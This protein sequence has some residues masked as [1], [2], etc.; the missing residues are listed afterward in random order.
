A[1]NAKR[2]IS[3]KVDNKSIHEVLNT[4][5][6]GAVTAKEKGN[7]IILTK[8]R[9]TTSS[10]QKQETFILNGYVI[11]ATDSSKIASASVYERN[12]MLSTITDRYGFFSLRIDKP[13]EQTSVYISKSDYID[14]VLIFN[15][16]GQHFSNIAL[17]KRI[18]EKTEEIVVSEIASEIYT[19]AI[20]ADSIF[21]ADVVEEEL[22][23]T[24]FNFKLPRFNK[25]L[26]INEENISDTL[27]RNFQ[28]SLVP[29]VGTNRKLSGNA[30]N[31]Y[32]LNI[33]GGYSMGNTALEFGGL[34]NLN[35]AVVSG[36]QISG[37]LNLNEGKTNAWQM[38]GLVNLQGDDASGAHMAGLLNLTSGKADGFRLAGLSNFSSRTSKGVSVAGLTNIQNKDYEGT[39]V[40]GLFNFTSKEMKGVQVAPFNYAK[41]MKGVQVGVINVADSASHVPI[42]FLTVVFKGYHKADVYTDEVI[43]YNL[44]LRTGVH[45]FHNI[46]LAGLTPGERDKFLWTF[47]YGLGTSTNVQRR[48][49]LYA[50]L[51][52][53]QISQRDFTPAI[54]LLNK[55]HLGFDVKLTG[56]MSLIVGATYNYQIIRSDYDNYPELFTYYTPSYLHQTISGTITTRSWVG[57][58]AGLR[59]F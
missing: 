10:T 28:V 15:T 22:P 45:Q 4:I 16:S 26:H 34:A 20:D 58:K 18:S 5:F 9:T 51:T 1:F 23:R 54:N 49:R 6:E 37:L 14:T 21:I 39:Q 48:I 53:Q 47:G 17:Q 42:G 38:A 56:V 2:T 13:G 30:V 43:T 46:L 57:F 55:V 31:K 40:A 52:A 36:V 27:Y 11:D 29:F 7:Y 41:N 35:R 44:A 32:S 59:F 12:S 3:L 24:K 25:Q 33:L 50:D 19:T 8:T